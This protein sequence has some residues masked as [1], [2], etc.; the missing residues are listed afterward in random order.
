MGQKILHG[1]TLDICPACGG[2][3]IDRKELGALLKPPGSAPT[4]MQLEELKKELEWSAGYDGTPHRPCPKCGER[5]PRHLFAALSGIAIDFCGKDG[6]WCDP[7][8]FDRLVAFVEKGGL[9]LAR[10]KH[11][12]EA[13]PGLAPAKDDTPLPR[14]MRVLNRAA[15]LFT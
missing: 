14:V 11:W 5:M 1:Q 9:Q 12:E 15:S 2:I 10:L 7:G 4:A 3:W 13:L 6:L 8:E